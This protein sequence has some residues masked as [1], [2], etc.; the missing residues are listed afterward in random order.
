MP[1]FRVNL[2]LWMCNKK[3]ILQNIQLKLAINFRILVSIML[4]CSL[5]VTI[6]FRFL[7]CDQEIERLRLLQRNL[8]SWLLHVDLKPY[9]TQG[10]NQEGK[11]GAGKSRKMDKS[12]LGD[13]DNLPEE[14]KARMSTMIDQLQIRDRLLVFLLSVYWAGFSFTV[15]KFL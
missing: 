2:Y 3:L 6:I 12:M 11:R 7:N 10:R 5:Y 15:M 8:N 13:L 14:D 4:F 9:S 1:I